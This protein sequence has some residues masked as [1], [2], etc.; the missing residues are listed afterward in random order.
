MKFAHT[1]I[2]VA[3][4]HSTGKSTFLAELGRRL[5]GHG[6]RVGRVADVASKASGLGFPILRDHVYESTL[7]IIA[8]GLRQEMEEAL[9]SEVVL[10]DRP[11]FDAVGYL[12]AA[13]D[14][15]QRTE[16]RLAELATIAEV[17]SP[18]YDWV[19]VTVLDEA[20]PLGPDRDPDLSFR[21]G[22]AKHIE[23]LVERFAPGA[24]RVERERKA[25]LLDQAVEFVLSRR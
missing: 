15:T 17:H 23:E 11:V 19:G 21:A 1:R 14:A 24:V 9:R 25:E 16:S 7:W 3:G 8:E 10:V 2:A 12:Q 5:E 4:T 18:Y 6:L 22:A 13:L 20:M